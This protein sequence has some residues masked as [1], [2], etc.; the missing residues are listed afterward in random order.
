[1][2]PS[3]S[4]TTATALTPPPRPQT[5]KTVCCCLRHARTWYYPSEAIPKP[6]AP[7]TPGIIYVIGMAMAANAATR[8]C[9]LAAVMRPKRTAIPAASVK[10]TMCSLTLLMR[11][12]SYTRYARAGPEPRESLNHRS[13]QK[14]RERHGI[15]CL[16]RSFYGLLQPVPPTLM[17]LPTSGKR[18]LGSIPGSYTTHG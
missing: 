18:F 16:S 12:A 1:M 3:T 2:K 14:D 15:R 10:K 11:L 9:G 4:S 5:R 7:R 13:T 6:F 17:S 8:L